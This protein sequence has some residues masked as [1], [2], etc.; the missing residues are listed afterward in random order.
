MIRPESAHIRCVAL[1]FML[2]NALALYGGM[3]MSGKFSVSTF[4]VQFQLVAK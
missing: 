1:I 4:K 2:G 3:Q